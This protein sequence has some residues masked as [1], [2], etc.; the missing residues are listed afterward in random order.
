MGAP[1]P[2]YADIVSLRRRQTDALA[3]RGMDALP[4]P[5]QQF[6]SPAEAPIQSIHP[7][8]HAANTA[9]L[10]AR[11]WRK[12]STKAG[13]QWTRTR[14]PPGWSKCGRCGEAYRREMASPSN[15]LVLRDRSTAPPGLRP[16]AVWRR[17]DKHSSSPIA[18]AVR[19]GQRRRLCLSQSSP[20]TTNEVALRVR[21]LGA[22][23]HRKASAG[24]SPK[25]ACRR[26]NM[27]HSS[28]THNPVA[29]RHFDAAP[30]EGCRTVGART[31]Q[32]A[33]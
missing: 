19:L 13:G 1:R 31:T 17:S 16:D 9:W 29:Q 6:P 15:K 7:R 33:S 4:S 5:S 14:T 23:A 20:H 32:H 27:P 8:L 2:L 28:T 22:T 10:S 3:W 21:Y 24:E 25:L 18:V 12:G 26:P 30:P 11:T